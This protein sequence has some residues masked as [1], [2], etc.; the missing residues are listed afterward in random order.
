MAKMEYL[1]GILFIL[2]DKAVGTSTIIKQ[3]EKASGKVKPLNT[4]DPMISLFVGLITEPPQSVS[5]HTTLFLVKL[6]EA[7]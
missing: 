3:T 6:W 5:Q 4:W 7:S 1:T 2:W